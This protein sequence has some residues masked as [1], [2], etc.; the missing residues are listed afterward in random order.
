MVH[1]SHM[2]PT[3]VM[4]WGRSPAVRVAF[5]VVTTTASTCIQLATTISRWILATTASS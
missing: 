1:G 4:L 3:P 2:G 5:D